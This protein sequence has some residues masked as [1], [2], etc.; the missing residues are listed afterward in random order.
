M[1][2]YMRCGVMVVGVNRGGHGGLRYGFGFGW[3][4]SVYKLWCIKVCLIDCILRVWTPMGLVEGDN[5][6][7]KM[8]HSSWGFI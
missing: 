3:N 8:L 6:G 4:F 7:T 5:W 1:S 2:L